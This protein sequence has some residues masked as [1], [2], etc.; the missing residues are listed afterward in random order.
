MGRGGAR[1]ELIGAQWRNTA[2]KEQGRGIALGVSSD[3]VA[4]PK[5]RAADDRHCRDAFVQC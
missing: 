1:R 5:G 2:R 4:R 3:R